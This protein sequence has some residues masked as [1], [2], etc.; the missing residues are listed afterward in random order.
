MSRKACEFT[1]LRTE[2][3][4]PNFLIMSLEEIDQSLK[5]TNY[6]NGFPGMNGRS[7]VRI[8]NIYNLV[9]KYFLVEKNG[10]EFKKWLKETG[11][12]TDEDIQDC[13]GALTM[14][15]GHV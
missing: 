1:C 8:G 10:E 13:Y 15:F 14:K 11:K 3:F 9:S 4:Y 7:W 5:E 12:M 2:T 6:R